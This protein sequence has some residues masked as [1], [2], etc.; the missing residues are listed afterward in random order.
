MVEIILSQI[1]MGPNKISWN[2]IEM[3][4]LNSDNVWWTAFYLYKSLLAKGFNTT[5]ETEY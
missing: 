4:L 2:S 3:F 5:R 1:L